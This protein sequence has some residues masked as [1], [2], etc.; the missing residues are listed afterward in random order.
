MGHHELSSSQ[1]DPVTPADSTDLPQGGVR[2]SLHKY[3]GPARWWGPHRL[4]TKATNAL[5]FA[6]RTMIRNLVLA[7]R[8]ARTRA[9]RA[10]NFSL[11]AATVGGMTAGHGLQLKIGVTYLVQHAELFMA[12]PSLLTGLFTAVDAAYT[13][14]NG[15]VMYT[16]ADILRRTGQHAW[17]NRDETVETIGQPKER[18]HRPSTLAGDLAF[19]MAGQMAFLAVNGA[20][21]DAGL[22]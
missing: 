3:D 8:D 10:R 6:G 16:Q 13:A 12:H 20:G 19:T 15:A 4:L 21:L 5:P 14:A 17:Q 22:S 9:S 2:S 1:G 7:T 18:P 11:L